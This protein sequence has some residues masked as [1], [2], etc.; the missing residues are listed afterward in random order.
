MQ[1]NGLQRVKA[2][3][4]LC[5]EV[6]TR[7]YGVPYSEQGVVLETVTNVSSFPISR[8]FIA[9]STLAATIQIFHNSW[10]LT[11]KIF[12]MLSPGLVWD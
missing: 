5:R 8:H 7:L 6:V 10:H 3:Y 9:A 11:A 12:P 1:T 2:L 4:R